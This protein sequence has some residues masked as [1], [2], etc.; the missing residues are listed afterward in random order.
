[1][2]DATAKKEER[3]KFQA[4]KGTRDIRP[5]ETALWNRVEQTAHDVFSTFGYGE[6]REGH[7]RSPSTLMSAFAKMQ[8]PRFI[9]VT[10]SDKSEVYPA[11]R[12][13]FAT[14]DAVPASP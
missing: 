11:L 9:S 1:M 2:S 4:I 12:K 8:D 13:F 3:R 7:Y 10:I 5:P 6:I 14:R